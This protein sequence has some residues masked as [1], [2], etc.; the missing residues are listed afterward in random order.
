MGKYA[1]D[2]SQGLGVDS[3]I[4]IARKYGCPVI[5]FHTAHRHAIGRWDYRAEVNVWLDGQWKR[6]TIRVRGGVGLK[7]RREAHRAAAQQWAADHLSCDREWAPTGLPD[8]WM[9]K[10]TKDRMKA[11]L[12][13]WRHKTAHGNGT[14]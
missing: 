11:D 9:P 13:A 5:D 10:D 14:T 1:D 8:S 3:P 7:E 6:K 12:T 4:D 2:L